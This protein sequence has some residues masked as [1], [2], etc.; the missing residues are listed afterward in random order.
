MKKTSFSILIL[1]AV[2]LGGC[3]DDDGMPLP[4]GSLLPP[5]GGM[6]DAGTD[7]GGETSE[8]GTC[9]SPRTLT[10][11]MGSATTLTGDTTGA[12]STVTIETCG[13]D[14]A[15]P[16]DVIALTIPGDP[17]EVYAVRYDFARGGTPANFDT[18]TQVRVTCDDETDA[19]CIDDGAE[20][21][22]DYRSVGQFGAPGGSTR[23][24]IVTGYPWDEEYVSAGAYEASFEVVGPLSA[25]VLTGGTVLNVDGLEQR[26]T[27]MGTDADMDVVGFSVQ[28]LDAAGN[29]IGIDDDGDAE[30]PP[31][32]TFEFGLQGVEGLASFTGTAI[33]GSDGVTELAEATHARIALIDAVDLRSA[34]MD[35]ALTAGSFSSL[36]EA[37]D[38]TNICTEGLECVSDA[39]A[40]PAAVQTACDGATELTLTTTS[41]ATVVT[42][43]AGEGHL[44][45][46]CGLSLFGPGTM[47]A[48]AFVEVTGAEGHDIVIETA[49]TTTGETDTVVYAMTTCGDPSSEVACNDDRPDSEDTADSRLEILD[50]EA[51]TYTIAVE[52]F[53]G[54]DAATM[55]D[56]VGR[57]RP[58]LATGAACDPAGVM[59]RCSSGACPST[60]EAVCP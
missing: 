12:P 37:C 3:G 43:P 58:V 44:I 49:G 2:M 10:L 25:P 20:G 8:A 15:L 33:I 16:Q 59:N 28:F 22:G 48:E 6:A 52:V 46:S 5:D 60:G 41:S 23:F 32:E 4:D 27:L 17:G 39:C 35:I 56:L 47:G 24:L 11:A 29:A 13:G 40:V 45:A 42:V 31:V 54:V 53:G 9:E 36:G 38:A 7:G 30:T 26:F 57:L 14:E 34:T 21:D 55:V 18:V 19:V 50:S 1:A 51:R